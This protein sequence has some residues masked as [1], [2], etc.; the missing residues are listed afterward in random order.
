MKKVKPQGRYPEGLK[1]QIAKEYLGGR[2]SA[3]YLTEEHGLKYK[4]LNLTW[5]G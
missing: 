3:G 2:A 4:E 1:R 5:T